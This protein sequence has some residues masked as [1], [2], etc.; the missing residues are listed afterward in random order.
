M[1]DTVCC[2]V[3]SYIYAFLACFGHEEGRSTTEYWIEGAFELIFVI[4]IVKNFV[5]DFIPQG[6]IV[7]EKNIMLIG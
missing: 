5:T 2:L 7:P 3:S 6:G 1:L 4:S